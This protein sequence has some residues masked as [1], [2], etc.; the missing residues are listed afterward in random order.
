MFWPQWH[1]NSKLVIYSVCRHSLTEMWGQSQYKPDLQ[2]TN[3]FKWLLVSEIVK[4]FIIVFLAE[5]NLSLSFRRWDKVELHCKGREGQSLFM[6]VTYTYWINF[7]LFSCPQTKLRLHQ[8]IPGTTQTHTSLTHINTLRQ[9]RGA[10]MPKEQGVGKWKTYGNEPTLQGKKKIKKGTKH[11]TTTLPRQ[12]IWFNITWI[13]IDRLIVF[14]L[15]YFLV[16]WIP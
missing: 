8:F 2:N 13:Q 15:L 11:A 14:L 5:Q 6:A 16:L 3:L 10:K 4:N 12:N 1:F 7:H 9:F